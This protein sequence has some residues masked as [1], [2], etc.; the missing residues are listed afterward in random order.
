[1]LKDML[2]ES[3]ERMIIDSES[4]G[5]RHGI[6]PIECTPP[7]ANNLRE[8]LCIP[9]SIFINTVEV[10]YIPCRCHSP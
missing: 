9:F 6:A 5:I 1:M 4:L 2:L 7:L 8:F 3:L 10:Q